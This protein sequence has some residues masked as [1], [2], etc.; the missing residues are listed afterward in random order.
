MS[1]P[2][3][4][5]WTPSRDRADASRMAEFLRWLNTERGLEFKD[6]NALWEWSVAD[7]DAFWQAI[8]DFFDLR[9]SAPHTAVL[10]ERRMPGAVWFPG[11]RLNFAENI[12][13][14]AETA[15]DAPALSTHRRKEG[16]LRRTG[17]LRPAPN[18]R[19]CRAPGPGHGRASVRRRS[20]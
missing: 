3:P 13:R 15:P 4:I 5:L 11:A 1:D 7:L 18:A 17:R 12:L 16:A 2:R 8:W 14:T 19:P 6:Y 9:A 10:A 20:G